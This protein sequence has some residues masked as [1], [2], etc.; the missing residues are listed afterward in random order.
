MAKSDDSTKKIEAQKSVP[1]E[2]WPVYEQLIAEYKSSSLEHVGKAWVN[3]Q[4]L[5]DLVN[6]GWRPAHGLLSK[7]E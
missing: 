2:L 3:Y 5:A 7:A 1:P 4:I 6:A